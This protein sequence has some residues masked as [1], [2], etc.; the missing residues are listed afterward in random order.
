[1]AKMVKQFELAQLLSCPLCG[2][3]PKIRRQPKYTVY[4][5]GSQDA[6]H[7]LG[8][9]PMGYER[10]FE[11]RNAWNNLVQKIKEIDPTPD[12]TVSNGIS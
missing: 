1:M 2:K 10:E 3:E 9:N 6:P 12:E 8:T 4:C 5:N 7:I 11:A